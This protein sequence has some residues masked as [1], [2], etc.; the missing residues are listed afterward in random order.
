MMEKTAANLGKKASAIQIN[1]AG[2]EM[3]RLVAP[4]ATESPT[5]LEK[6]DW[7]SPPRKPDNTEQRPPARIPPLIFFIS[8]RFHW[9]S[10]I[11]SQ[12]VRSPTVLRMEQTLAIMKGKVMPRLKWCP[13]GSWG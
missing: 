9:A 3:M 12:N 7:P 1:P 5:L 6:V 8:V 11:F 13:E 4:V 2:Q 10:L